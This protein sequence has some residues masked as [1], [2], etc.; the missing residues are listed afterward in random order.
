MSEISQQTSVSDAASSVSDASPSIEAP[1]DS[2][3]VWNVGEGD[4]ARPWYDLIPEEAARGHVEAKG[5]RNPA[6]LALANFSLTKLQRGDPTVIGFPGDNATPEQMDEFYKKL[7]RP[8][9][10]EGY[11][12]N[13]SEN[14]KVDDAMVQFARSAFHEAGLTPVQAQSVADKWNQFAEQQSQ[15]FQTQIAE[16]NDKELQ[17]LEAEWGGDLEK[18]KAAGQRAV[19]ALGLDADTINRIEDSIGS[20]SIVKLLAMIGRKSDEGGFTGGLQNADPNDPDTMDKA[21]IANRIAELRNDS[22]FLAKYTDKNNPQ[23][24][25]ALNLMERLY[26]KA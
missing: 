22:E 21:Q 20:A 13:F 14:V 3:G 4:A 15:S 12:F 26:A 23:H 9:G 7:G 5:Y 16:Q 2:E 19:Q 1:W 6:E 11:K 8:E 18:N 25:Q 24:K 10:P 17:A